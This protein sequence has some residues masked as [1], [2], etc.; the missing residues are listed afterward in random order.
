MNKKA[1]LGIGAGALIVLLILFCV[2]IVGVG[3]V[4]IVTRF[5]SVNREVQSGI[6]LKLPWPIEHITK[7][8]I[9]NQKV[10]VDASAATQDLQ[11]VTTSV[12]LNFNLTPASADQVYREVGTNYQLVVIDPILQETVKSVTSGY[13]AT[14]LIDQRPKVEA[15]TLA[16]LQK[17]LE[18]KGITIDNFSIVN[19]AFSS[20][21]SSAIENKQVE[22]QN[23]QA[24]QYKLQQANLNAQANQVQD[25]ALTPNILEQQAI[26]KWD[27]K[28]PS[29]TVAGSSTLFSIPVGGS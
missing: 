1:K 8:N 19:F 17:A 2:R 23:V 15:Q 28:L 12:A 20:A 18:P 21:F 14:D 10:Q 16:A 24:A 27:G 6:H 7:M 25:A 9:Q 22:A 4:G 26:A 11:T 13:N 29:N 5:G 3:Q